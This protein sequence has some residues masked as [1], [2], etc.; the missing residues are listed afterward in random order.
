MRGHIGGASRD[1]GTVATEANGSSTPRPR[2]VGKGAQRFSLGLCSITAKAA[3]N[4]GEKHG[5]QRRGGSL[6]TPVVSSSA[7]A[8][9]RR[10]PGAASLA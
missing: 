10:A 6:L 7:I 9:V 5:P 2:P 8:A 4:H 1:V 3:E